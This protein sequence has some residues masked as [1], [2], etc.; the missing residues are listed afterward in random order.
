MKFDV[1]G[2]RFWV[3][4]RWV[5][6]G[7]FRDD[8]LGALQTETHIFERVVEGSLDVEVRSGCERVPLNAE[9]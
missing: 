7:F 1:Q 8:F 2:L 6:E 4:G 9:P 5:S 3:D